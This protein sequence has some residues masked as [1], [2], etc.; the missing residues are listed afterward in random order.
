MRFTTPTASL[1]KACQLKR[2]DIRLAGSSLEVLYQ[3]V[4]EEVQRLVQVVDGLA[5]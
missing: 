2:G 1:R 3:E 5:A 4:L